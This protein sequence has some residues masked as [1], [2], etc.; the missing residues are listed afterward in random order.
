MR[1]TGEVKNGA[2]VPPTLSL[3]AVRLTVRQNTTSGSAGVRAFSESL[4]PRAK[5]RTLPP[6]ATHPPLSTLEISLSIRGEGLANTI[7]V[8]DAQS[9]N[10]GARCVTISTRD[11]LGSMETGQRAGGRVFEWLT[12]PKTLC[13]QDRLQIELKQNAQVTG[14]HFGGF[15]GNPRRSRFF[16]RMEAKTLSGPARP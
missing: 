2:E 10:S 6:G 5:F 9:R 8:Y 14:A 7:H 12:R 16:L 13:G 1:L 15:L 11:A 4:R 3:R